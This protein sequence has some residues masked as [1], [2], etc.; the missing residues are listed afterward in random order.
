MESRGKGKRKGKGVCP[1]LKPPKQ[2]KTLA[3]SLQPT[4]LVPR[5]PTD[6][7]KGLW[8]EKCDEVTWSA[9]RARAALAWRIGLHQAGTRRQQCG[10]VVDGRQLVVHGNVED[11]QAGYNALDVRSRRR[12]RSHS[13]CCDNDLVCLVAIEF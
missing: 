1:G 8:H 11:S 6:S 2:K 7:E 10:Y 13:A 5:R 4:T 3:T 9:C 12:W